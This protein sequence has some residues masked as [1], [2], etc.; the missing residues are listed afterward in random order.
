MVG[1]GLTYII[2]DTGLAF[3]L[4]KI[5]FLGVV[6]IPITTYAFSVHFLGDRKQYPFIYI[7]TLFTFALSLFINAP[8]M[9]IGLFSYSWGNYIHLGPLS[10]IVIALFF[11]FVPLFILNLYRKARQA[12]LEQKRW[13]N[14]ALLTGSL[15]FLGVVDFLPAYGIGLPFPPIGYLLTSSFATLLGYFI[16]RHQ[17]A[18]IKFFLG[19]TIGYGILTTILFLIYISFFVAFFPARRNILDLGFNT[20]LFIIALFTFSFLKQKSQRIVDEIFFKERIDFNRL[21]NEFTIYL[22]NLQTPDLLLHTLFTFISQRL[23]IESSTVFIFSPEEMR[24]MMFQSNRANGDPRYFDAFLSKSFANFFTEY[25]EPLNISEKLEGLGSHAIPKVLLDDLREIL[26][27]DLPRTH[28]VIPLIRRS[29]FFGII[30]LGKKSSGG[31]YT[32]IEIQ[33]LN[34]I[35]TPFAIAWENAALY[36]YMQETSK[37]KSDFISIASH[38]LRTPLTHIKWLLYEVLTGELGKVQSKKQKTALDQV[39]ANTENM[40]LLIKQ[41]LDI[42]RIETSVLKP[43]STLFDFVGLLDEIIQAYTGLFSEKHITLKSNFASSLPFL[44][45]HKE[46]VR[47]VVTVLLENAL[48]YTQ[49]GGV[50]TI[51][52]T[53]PEERSGMLLAVSDTGIGIPDSQQKYIF[54]RFF[55]ADNAIAQH[56]NGTG[57]GLFYAKLLVERG[58]GNIWFRSEE[59]KETTFYVLFPMREQD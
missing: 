3:L 7:G 18:D 5:G 22:R 36:G 31:H 51:K 21:I 1:M 41:L 30:A 43:A 28:L 59:G 33:S 57:L 49:Q 50:V 9:S 38:Q 17:L 44:R 42:V 32:R 16:L 27:E 37:A 12:P 20:V 15:A 29:S 34:N 40:I 58:R 24:W 54:N 2:A 47:T 11:I 19:Q 4:A 6:Y 23:R 56:P 14:L 39:Y 53:A 45:A 35:A 52:V 10:Y 48:R 46:H 8:E 13:H 55:R 26:G 25:P